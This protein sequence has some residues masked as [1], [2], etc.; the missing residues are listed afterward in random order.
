MYNLFLTLFP[1]HAALAARSAGAADSEAAGGV[2][3]ARHFKTTAWRRLLQGTSPASA[4][5]QS[6]LVN[7][8]GSN[9]AV[10]AHM[11]VN[12]CM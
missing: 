8:L 9:T 11:L 2:R 7:D 6:V 4:M 12:H 10:C 3:V 1:A 5:Q